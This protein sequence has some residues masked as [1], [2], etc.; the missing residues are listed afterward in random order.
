VLGEIL[1]FQQVIDRTPGLAAAYTVVIEGSGECCSN[2]T[3]EEG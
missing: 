3:K 2:A 1:S